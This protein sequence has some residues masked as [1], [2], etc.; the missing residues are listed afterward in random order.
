MGLG[1]AIAR[2]IAQGVGDAGNKVVDDRREAI[3]DKRKNEDAFTLYTKQSDYLAAKQEKVVANQRTYQEGLTAD[4]RTYNAGLLTDERQHQQGVAAQQHAERVQ[5]TN[6]RTANAIKTSRVQT[7][8]S[9]AS[10]RFD[11][12][13]ITDQ[14][15]RKLAGMSD[16]ELAAMKA[17]A[18]AKPFGVDL[19]GKMYNES[20][21]DSDGRTHAQLIKDNGGVM[22]DYSQFVGTEFASGIP[23]ANGL[24]GMDMGSQF[25]YDPKA[26]ENFMKETNEKLTHQQEEAIATARV[27]ESNVVGKQQ[28]PVSSSLVETIRINTKGKPVEYVDAEGKLRNTHDD[29]FEALK[30]SKQILQYEGEWMM[31]AEAQIFN[32]QE[33]V[34]QEMEQQQLAIQNAGQGTV[35]KDQ[36]EVA[37][38]ADIPAATTDRGVDESA[39]GIV[40]RERREKQQ[41]KTTA[42]IKILNKDNDLQ[43][44]DS[45]SEIMDDITGLDDEQFDVEGVG[46]SGNSALRGGAAALGNEKAKRAKEVLSKVAFVRNK[47][48]NKLFGA[49]LTDNEQA[50]FNE[51][52]DEL[53]AMTTKDGYTRQLK[54]VQGLIDKKMTSVLAESDEETQR[55]MARRHPQILRV[56]TDNIMRDNNLDPKHRAEVERRIKEQE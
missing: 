7:Q 48:R 50:S 30:S 23:T 1:S 51:A 37:P 10:K 49:T 40:Q 19:Y 54:V 16:K 52:W 2:G 18:F 13:Q 25:T 45:L 53:G 33:R 8:L 15:Y 35:L 43:N 27:I 36:T 14:K 24:G 39:A 55:D 22:A 12:T 11:G 9:A 34:Q 6:L 21:K 4:N 20:L 31:A 44:S 17:D 41:V 42:G 28:S 38:I 26:A 3:R 29:S 32:E 47:I 5:L 56:M 46:L